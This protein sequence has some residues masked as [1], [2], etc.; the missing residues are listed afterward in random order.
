MLK[1]KVEKDIQN[2][3]QD[4]KRA[5]LVYGVRQAGKT[6][7]IRHCLESE[8]CSYIEFNLIR[9][10][11]I[12]RILES[13]ADI[14]DLILKL[15]LYSEKRIV[16]GETILFFEKIQRNCNQDKIPCGRSKVSLHSERFTSWR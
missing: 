13:A 6:Y 4:D 12:I 1:R 14:D 15:S 11:D 3:L 2:W 9:E 8:G 16:P 7:I 10:P 5:L